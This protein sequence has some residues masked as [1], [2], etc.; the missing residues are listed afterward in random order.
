MLFRINYLSTPMPLTKEQLIYDPAARF[1]EASQDIWRALLIQLPYVVI[2]LLTLLLAWV[3]AKMTSALVVRVCHKAS[4]NIELIKIFGSVSHLAILL[5]GLLTAV[6]I[7]FPSFS[8]AHLFTGVGVTSVVLGFAFKNIFMNWFA[9]VTI[10][11]E[12]RYRVGDVIQVGEF[13][14]TVEDI[15]IDTTTLKTPGWH[16]IIIP[17]LEMVSKP[18]T[19][20]SP[21]AFRKISIPVVVMPDTDIDAAKQAAVLLLAQHKALVD[22]A[23]PPPKV[24]ITTL[25]E[26]GP[27]LEVH[28]WVPTSDDDDA[29]KDDVATQLL[30]AFRDQGIQ[31]ARPA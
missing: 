2:G 22:P 26:H 9:G 4:L 5:I 30:L 3:V 20:R 17:N 23:A 25:T 11:W 14:G 7:I 24:L 28:F 1:V 13:E 21:Y 8:F 27:K 16:R 10:L 18:L 19:I 12:K 31:F 6:V 15:D 29:V